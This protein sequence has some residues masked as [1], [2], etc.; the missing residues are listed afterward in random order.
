MKKTFII[1]ACASLSACAGHL[2]TTDK[3]ELSELRSAIQDAKDAGAEKCAPEALA[4]AEAKQLYAAHEI[5]EHG[6]YNMS[7]ADELIASGLKAAKA[8]KE[9]CTASQAVAQAKPQ[10]KPAPAPVV[11]T[12][13]VPVAT[14]VIVKPSRGYTDSEVI[15]LKG[16]N[17]DSNKA[18]LTASSQETLNHAVSV[19]K[20]RQDIKVEVAA[21]TDSGGKA[22]YN[23]YLSGLRANTVKD[24]LISHGIDA[25]RVTAKGYGEAYPIADN[26][27]RAG[28]A[29]N[30]RVE[31]IVK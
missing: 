7:E 20:E 15:D 6:G 10:K 21:H 22:S 25:S 26:K 19:L 5:D 23:E 3:G 27:T 16:I 13:P 17:F 4:K 31:L 12:K 2:P 29:K 11:K 30:R 24:Y 14:P 8:A 28:K 18:T 1:L 9:K